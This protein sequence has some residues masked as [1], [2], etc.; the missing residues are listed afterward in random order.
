MT[1][2]MCLML[3]AKELLEFVSCG[4]NAFFLFFQLDSETCCEH[5]KI[6][7]ISISLII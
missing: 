4:G 1:L 6:S 2:I 5:C 7:S 3:L